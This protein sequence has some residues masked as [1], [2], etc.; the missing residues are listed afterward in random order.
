M[1]KTIKVLLIED[2]DSIREIYKT[3][4]ELFGFAIDD[5]ATGLDGLNA[6]SNNSYDAVL[7]DI[8]LPDINGLNV[9]KQMKQDNLKK[10]IPVVLLTSL[11]QDI[12]IKQGLKLG[13]T[14]Y[15]QKDLITPDK[16]VEKLKEILKTKPS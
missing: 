14:A 7:L 2:E 12:I 13:A 9:L 15:L 4:L 6:F 10:E 3:E 16:L 11:H 5:F 1:Q 8:I